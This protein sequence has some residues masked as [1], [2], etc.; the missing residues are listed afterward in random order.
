MP[1]LLLLFLGIIEFGRAILTY[2]TIANAAREGAR[3]GIVMSTPDDGPVKS[4]ALA[5][6]AG[7]APPLAADHITVAWSG[8][9]I[10]VQINYSYPPLL[11]GFPGI[12]ATIPL[13]TQATMQREQ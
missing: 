5:L 11:A 1:L 13:H 12:P 6:S 2:N 3:H 7:L 10:Q 4:A 9:T 8:A